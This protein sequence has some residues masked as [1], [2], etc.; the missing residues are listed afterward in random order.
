MTVQ[1]LTIKDISAYWDRVCKAIN[2]FYFCYGVLR[3]L[4]RKSTPTHTEIWDSFTSRNAAEVWARKYFCNTPWFSHLSNGHNLRALAYQ[5]CLVVQLPAHEPHTSQLPLLDDSLACAFWNEI[6]WAISCTHD[7][8]LW[9]NVMREMCWIC[10][11]EEWVNE[12][13]MGRSEVLFTVLFDFKAL[14]VAGSSFIFWEMILGAL[15]HFSQQWTH[16]VRNSVI[17]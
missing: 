1:R 10:P 14:S 3:N 8:A 9:L 15:S 7:F 16:I 5:L 6:V 17:T 12:F 4:H 13:L 2:S 11:V